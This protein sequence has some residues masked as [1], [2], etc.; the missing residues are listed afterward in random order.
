MSALD[1]RGTDTFDDASDA[2][3][4]L[5]IL[6][7]DRIVFHDYYRSPTQRMIEAL[8]LVTSCFADSID[9]STLKAIR[10]DLPV[11]Q[12]TA[13]TD[14]DAADRCLNTLSK[15]CRTSGVYLYVTTTH[16]P[17]AAPI[18]LFTVITDYGSGHVVTEHFTDRQTRRE[19]LLGRAQ[20]FFASPEHIPDRILTDDQ[21]LAAM[22][23]TLLTPAQVHLTESVRNERT[24]VYI[25]A[26]GLLP[27]R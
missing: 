5:I 19:S 23:S 25:P 26:G 17:A 2:A 1:S 12:I 3:H 20:Q 16:R 14:D 6:D 27:V 7:G 15:L 24:G 18:E 22:I 10:R 4:D 11:S 13:L 9:A 8:R 21:R